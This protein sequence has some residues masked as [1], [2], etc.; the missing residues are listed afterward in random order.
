MHFFEDRA[1]WG[2]QPPDMLYPQS[3]QFQDRHWEGGRAKWALEQGMGVCRKL[4]LSNLP[5]LR[6]KGTKLV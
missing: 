6:Q 1:G 3:I 2:S 4:H 5:G